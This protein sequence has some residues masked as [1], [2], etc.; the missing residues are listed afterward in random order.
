M[1]GTEITLFESDEF[2]LELT[3]DGAGGFRADAPGVARQLGFREAHDLLR[4]I[5]DDERGSELVRTPN[6]GQ[7]R[8]SYLT[9]KGFYRAFG[10]RQAARVTNPDARDRVERFQSWVYGE[11]LPK[12]RRGELVLAQTSPPLPDISTPEGVLA[13][14]EQ[15]TT[16]A[17][18]LVQAEQDKARLTE[19][20]DV[21]EAA[22]DSAAPAIE[23]HERY[24][25]QDDVVTVKNWAGQFGLTDP[26]ARQLLVDKN[27]IYRTV[28]SQRYDVAADAMVPVYEYRARGSRVTFTWF[29]LRPQHRAPRHHNGQV[30]QTLYIRQQYA[31]DLGRKVGLVPVAVQPAL[32]EGDDTPGGA[33]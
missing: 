5:P 22:L 9:E 2:R 3:S 20:K 30:R 28:V 32:V 15:L 1:S 33:A 18:Q 16:T 8:R 13:L 24:V 26:Q 19:E 4:T 12:L 25:V 27:I 14:A 23:Y 11:V 6:G 7:Q 29:D 21:V 10:Q 17:R 31:L